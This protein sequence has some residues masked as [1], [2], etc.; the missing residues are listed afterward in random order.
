M[1]QGPKA[2]KKS[3][4]HLFGCFTR[5]NEGFGRERFRVFIEGNFVF[6]KPGVTVFTCIPSQATSWYKPIGGLM[7]VP[8]DAAYKIF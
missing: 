3:L 5:C 6:V 4:K 7:V 1:K 2:V 8:F